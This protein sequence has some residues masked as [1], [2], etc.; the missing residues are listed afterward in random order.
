MPAAMDEIQQLGTEDRF[1]VRLSA[2]H[3]DVRRAAVLG[4]D[5]DIDLGTARVLRAALRPVLEHETGPVVVDLS[6]VAFMDSTGVHVVVDTH[7]QLRRQ[8]RRL[9]IVCREGSQVHRVLGLLG[10]LDAVPVYRSRESAVMGGDDRLR[11]EPGRR[12]RTYRR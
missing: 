4:V 6:E 11:T 1:S 10:L 12:R 8:S 3:D 9:A 2:A 5:G 7:E